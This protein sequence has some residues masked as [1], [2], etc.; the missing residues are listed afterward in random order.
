MLRL[1]LT[2]LRMLW[3]VIADVAN[4]ERVKHS[5]AIQGEHT[6]SYTFLF[7]LHSMRLPRYARKDNTRFNYI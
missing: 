7:A 5:H 6:K 3:L 2:L 1:M 4:Y